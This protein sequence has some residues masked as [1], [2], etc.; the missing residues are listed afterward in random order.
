MAQIV[1]IPWSYV[2]IFTGH[3]A[4][5]PNHH[6]CLG[7]HESILASITCQSLSV[8][9]FPKRMRRPRHVLLHFSGSARDRCD[10][11]HQIN[12]T[13]TR[14]GYVIVVFIQWFETE[15][16]D[17][18]PLKC[19]KM[20]ILFLNLVTCTTHLKKPQDTF[21]THQWSFLLIIM[22]MNQ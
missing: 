18:L 15:L 21:R 3:I 5:P 8:R 6:R 13:A 7:E 12:S 9:R 4:W 17:T 14:N 10:G 11:G 1:M 19:V 20:S 16:F 2:E 22:F